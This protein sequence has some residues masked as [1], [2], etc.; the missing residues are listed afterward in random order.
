MSATYRQSAKVSDAQLKK[1]PENIYLS[2]WPR[3]RLKAEFVRDMCIG[4]QRSAGKNDWW[5]QCKTLPAKRSLGTG[6][7]RS[8]RIGYLPAGS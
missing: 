5:P 6:F 1:D 2:R 3:Q 7:F 4:K 8:W